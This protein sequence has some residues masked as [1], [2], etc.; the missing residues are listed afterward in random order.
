[1]SFWEAFTGGA[2][3]AVGGGLF[4][5]FYNDMNRTNADH[6]MDRAQENAEMQ[7]G[8]QKYMSNT[9]HQREVAD[10]KAAGLNPVLSGTG[11]AGAASP[12]GA[13]GGGQMADVADPSSIISNAMEASKLKNVLKGQEASNALL[14]AQKDSV[15]AQAE[16]TRKETKLMVPMEMLGDKF[17]QFFQQ[18]AQDFKKGAI[19]PYVDKAGEIYGE[20]IQ[21]SKEQDRKIKQAPF[22]ETGEVIRD[23]GRKFEKA[24]R[25]K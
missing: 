7:M 12:P 10:L 13:A 5:G 8:F 25:G 16:K 17:R 20:M 23:Y 14:E 21:R 22:G 18:G 3:S 2:G 15:Q 24:T 6:A 11:G 19:L 1:M 4:Q 9:A